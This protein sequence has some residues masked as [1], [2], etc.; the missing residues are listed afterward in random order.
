MDFV[1]VGMLKSSQHLIK[2]T[3]YGHMQR[4]AQDFIFSLILITGEEAK[5]LY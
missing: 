1:E 5:H 3:T 4:G 2:I